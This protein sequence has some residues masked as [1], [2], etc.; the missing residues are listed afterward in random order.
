MS[1][2]IV[3][4]IL[5]VYNGQAHIHEAL[6]SLLSQTLREIEIL[7]ID[8]GSTDDTLEAVASV[9]DPRIQVFRQPNEGLVAKLNFGLVQARGKYI[10]RMDADDIS[11][12]TRLAS[13]VAY[14]DAHPEIGVCG[15]ASVSFTA[16]GKTWT[17][18]QPINPEV[19]WAT[20]LLRVPLSHPTV[21]FRGSL[22]R[23]G[24]WKY[25][26]EASH[27]EDYD[28]WARF[29]EVTKIGN[30]TAPLLRYRIHP[31]QV[32]AQHNALQQVASSSVRATLLTKFLGPT[33]GDLLFHEKLVQQQW[34]T[35]PGFLY[36]FDGW[37]QRI[38]EANKQ[39][40]R[41]TERALQEVFRPVWVS[42]ALAHRGQGLTLRRIQKNNPLIGPKHH[43]QLQILK[44]RTRI[45]L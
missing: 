38:W 8:D 20:L 5:P 18:K 29:G 17:T 21:M 16:S 10:A 19:A 14:L 27:A 28:L 43:P 25:R 42:A 2:P 26:P 24:G 22:M 36:Q 3:S 9:P 7:V 37:L 44:L 12:P 39:A 13:Q 6:Q 4:V 32:S 35:N 41:Y 1:Q 45:G 23:E 31:E 34:G 33:T 11:L 15:T 40:G 30:L